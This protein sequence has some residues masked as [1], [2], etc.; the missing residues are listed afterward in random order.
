M[1]W[2]SNTIKL[3]STKFSPG[4]SPVGGNPVGGI[5]GI[6]TLGGG[7]DR[8]GG[9]IETPPLPGGGTAENGFC[10]ILPA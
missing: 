5:P 3:F 6:G 2:L 10:A 9:G 8:L 7:P 1:M 4:G